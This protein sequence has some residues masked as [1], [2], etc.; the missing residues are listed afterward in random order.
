M[1]TNYYILLN[2]LVLMHRKLRRIDIDDEVRSKLNRAKIE[3]A[4]VPKRN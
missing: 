2:Y 1:V 4:K 3:E